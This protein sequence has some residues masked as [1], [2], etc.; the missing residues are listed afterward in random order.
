[1]VEELDERAEKFRFARQLDGLVYP[2]KLEKKRRGTFH[3]EFKR[4]THFVSN[5]N[6][7]TY[8]G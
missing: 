8:F 7:L 4:S 2:I 6:C 5:A 1:M 3:V